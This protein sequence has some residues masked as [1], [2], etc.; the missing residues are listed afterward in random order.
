LRIPL[1]ETR[2]SGGREFDA[3]FAGDKFVTRNLVF[4]FAD[5]GLECS[6]LGVIAGKKILAKAVSRNRFKRRTRALFR[7]SLDRL[8]G[9]DVVV[10]AR[11][12]K[13]LESYQALKECF[14]SFVR[15]LGG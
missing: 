5:S 15:S 12:G 3:A 8:K 1:K 11:K 9:R 13:R 4:Y 2:L 6:R 7:Q 10:I 14:E